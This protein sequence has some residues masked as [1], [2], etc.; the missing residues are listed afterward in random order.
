M[1][2]RTPKVRDGD[3]T[4]GWITSGLPTTSSELAGQSAAW[5]IRRSLALWLAVDL[6]ILVYIERT[7][8]FRDENGVADECETGCALAAFSDPEKTVD[9]SR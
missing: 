7:G 1:A 5:L 6:Q 4:A 2:T 9:F 3:Y 8:A